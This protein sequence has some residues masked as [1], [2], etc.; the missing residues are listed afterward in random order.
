MLEEKTEVYSH[1]C[2]PEICVDARGERSV[3]AT[4]V[5]LKYA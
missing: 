5:H 4:A 1:S 2:S 3:A